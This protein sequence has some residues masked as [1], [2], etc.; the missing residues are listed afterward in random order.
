V[1]ESRGPVRLSSRRA[2]SYDGDMSP[3][4]QEDMRPASIVIDIQKG[5]DDY[6]FWG[7]RD[8]PACE[9]DIVSIVGRWRFRR[10]PLAL[11]QHG[12]YNQELPL[13][14][15]SPG[16]EFKDLVTGAPDLLAR[17]K[18]NSSFYGTPDLH[19][20]LRAERMSQVM[21]CGS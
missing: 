18:M 9:T 1:H 12:S 17:R 14:S 16:G 13:A 5:L 21:I 4:A 6:E 7:P 11:V 20:R 19:A 3:S 10:W 8:N 15:G 2:L